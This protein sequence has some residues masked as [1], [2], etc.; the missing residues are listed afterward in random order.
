MNLAFTNPKRI[1]TINEYRCK[2]WKF[3][4]APASI[5]KLLPL[6]NR[7]KPPMYHTIAAR[8]INFRFV[9]LNNIGI[10]ISLD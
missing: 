4:S 1:A 5:N 3:L 2:Y 6:S 9:T 10:S 7:A 8:I